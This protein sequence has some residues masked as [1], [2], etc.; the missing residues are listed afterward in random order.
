M[1][2]RFEKMWEK[3]RRDPTFG[4]FK[5]HHEI[6]HKRNN[7]IRSYSTRKDIIKL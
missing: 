3:L 7:G 2:W 4:F 5:W 1:E 6:H